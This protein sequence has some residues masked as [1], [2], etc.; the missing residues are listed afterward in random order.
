MPGQ[1]RR[2]TTWPH[3]FPGRPKK[4]FLNVRFRSEKSSKD[5]A[6]DKKSEE[7]KEKGKGGEDGNE[8]GG[9]LI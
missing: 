3:S 4:A 2:K 1:P 8:G 5:N 9:E 7:E 6:D